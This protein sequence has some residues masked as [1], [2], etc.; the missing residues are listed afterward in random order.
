VRLAATALGV[1]LF[2][3]LS[4]SFRASAFPGLTHPANAKL[5]DVQGA[6]DLGNRAYIRA[7]VA[8]DPVAFGSLFTEDAISMPSQAPMIRGRDAI[9]DSMRAVFA[10]IAFEGGTLHTITTHLEGNTAIEIGAYHFDVTIAG[11]RRDLRGRYLVVWR[12]VDGAWL[13][14][15]D[16]S[17]PGAPAS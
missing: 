6:I 17:Q 5:V 2:V 13:I 9:V 7:L 8:H 11:G 4:S 16:S 12:R 14:A 10:R 15:V 1:F 3:G